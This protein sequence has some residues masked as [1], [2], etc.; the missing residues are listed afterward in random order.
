L[1]ACAYRVYQ[2]FAEKFAGRGLS[3][4]QVNKA[5]DD[6]EKAG[7]LNKKDPYGVLDKAK[8]TKD[9]LTRLGV[10]NAKVTYDSNPKGA[11]WSVREVTTRNG[12]PHTQAGRNDGGYDWDPLGADSANYSKGVEVKS[13]VH[14][15][16]PAAQTFFNWD[17]QR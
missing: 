6:L 11:L 14:I 13:F 2:Y 5:T 4:P 10:E 3:V 8:V 12:N 1:E 17:R 9:A 7:V 15:E 16:V